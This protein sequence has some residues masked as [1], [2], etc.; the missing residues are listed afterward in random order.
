MP[1][2]AEGRSELVHHAHMHTGGRLLGTLTREGG[3]FTVELWT[4]AGG[5]GDQERRRRAEARPGRD[6]G[7]HSYRL[8]RRAPLDAHCAQIV[9]AAAPLAF[10]PPLS[11]RL[12]ACPPPPIAPR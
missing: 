11:G 4:Q 12:P 10:H 5:D 1:A 6:V 3:L 8:Q 2:A 9:A 7:L